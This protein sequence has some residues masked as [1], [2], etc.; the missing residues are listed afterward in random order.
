MTLSPRK[1]GYHWQHP[2]RTPVVA[3]ADD[4]NVWDSGNIQSVGNLFVDV[5]DETWIYYCGRPGGHKGHWGND[6][7]RPS[8]AATGLAKLRKDGFFS[9]DAGEVEGTLTTPPLRFQMGKFYVNVDAAGGELA[10]DV[11]DQ[12]GKPLPD[13]ARSNC[14]QLSVNSTMAQVRWDNAEDLNR[15]KAQ[16]VRLRFHLRKG[17]LY[18]F[19]IAP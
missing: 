10:V 8:Y 4:D 17:S 11:I 6:G 13:F 5:G 9:I 1:H 18:G 3:V 12:H 2:S 16:P 14:R 15:L 19:Q 7:K